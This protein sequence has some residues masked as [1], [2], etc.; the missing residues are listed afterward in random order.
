MD[1]IKKKLIMLIALSMGWFSCSIDKSNC[2]V[3]QQDK[4]QPINPGTDSSYIK[5]DN[6]IIKFAV[7]YLVRTVVNEYLPRP[8]NVDP[9]SYTRHIWAISLIMAEGTDVRNLSPIIT[10]VPGATITPESGIVH[11]FTKQVSWTLISPK[12]SEVIYHSLACAIG[13]SLPYVK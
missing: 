7:P 9:K 2:N 8:F 4:Y 12:G 11:D 5:I 1:Y 3:D 6:N 10:L 13:D